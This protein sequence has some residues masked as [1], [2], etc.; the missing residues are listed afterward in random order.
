MTKRCYASRSIVLMHLLMIPI[1]TSDHATRA[2]FLGNILKG[3]RRACWGM[4]V[5]YW[6][7]GTGAQG[8]SHSRAVTLC[9]TEC[10][11]ISHGHRSKGTRIVIAYQA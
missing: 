10:V 4:A 6:W 2:D 7:R 8:R 9:R 5:T 11:E 1:M 3:A